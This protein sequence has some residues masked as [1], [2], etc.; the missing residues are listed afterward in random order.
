MNAPTSDQQIG[1]SQKTDATGLVRFHI[2]KKNRITTHGTATLTTRGRAGTWVRTVPVS[3]VFPDLYW[4]VKLPG[5]VVRDTRSGRERIYQLEPRPLAQ[6]QRQLASISAQ[7]DAAI[8][9]LKRFV[10]E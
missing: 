7:W 9:R 6:A 3:E 8:E 5:G 1:K 10:E 4:R 2:S